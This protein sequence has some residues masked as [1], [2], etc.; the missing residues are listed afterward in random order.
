MNLSS[1]SLILFVF[2]VGISSQQFFDWISDNVTEN[3]NPSIETTKRSTINI[4]SST[5]SP[6]TTSTS[7]PT[8][9]TSTST[10]STTTST[11]SLPSTSSPFIQTTVSPSTLST[12]RLTTRE[13]LIS[14]T[15]ETK[16]STD[17]SLTTISNRLEEC[18]FIE[19][20]ARITFKYKSKEGYEQQFEVIGGSENGELVQHSRCRKEQNVIVKYEQM[21]DS[22]LILS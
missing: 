20:N 13:S 15:I 6:V 22:K 12:K 8:S 9:P 2:C 5:L 16:P 4:I 18:L 21:E 11:T 7:E 10:P 17:G 1:V 14:S 19:F 3:N